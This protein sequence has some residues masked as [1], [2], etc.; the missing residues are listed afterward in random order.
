MTLKE[1]KQKSLRLIEEISEGNSDLTEDPDIASKIND[2]VNQIQFELTRIKKLPAKT[3]IEI[4]E[5]NKIYT[6]TDEMYQVF[7]ITGTPNFDIIGKEIIFPEDFVGTATI[8]YYK[9]P[10]SITSETPDNQELELPAE[11]LEIMPYGIAA[12]IL[13]S[14]VSNAYGNIYSQRYETMKQ[15]LDPRYNMGFIEIGE[16]I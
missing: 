6:M 7:K 13:K 1:I 12:D 8:Y 2:V 4:D 3:E 16:G 15:Q 10:E 11:I 14:D 5:E 9:Y